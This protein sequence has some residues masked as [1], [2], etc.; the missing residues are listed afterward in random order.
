MREIWDRS[1]QPHIWVQYHN[2]LEMYQELVRARSPNGPL[3]VLDVGCAQATLALLLSE[4]GH[5]VLAIDLRQQFLQY[6]ASRYTHG[7]IRFVRANAL[8]FETQER[9][10]V[11]FANQIVEHLVYPLQLLSRLHDLLATNGMLVVTTPNWAYAVSRLPSFTELGEASQYDDRQ[12]SADGDG[13]FFAYKRIELIKLFREAGLS[14]IRAQYFESPFVSGHMKV[15][16]A[17][18]LA[19]ESTLKLLDRIVLSVPGLRRVVAHQLLVT[20]VKE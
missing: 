19:P 4:A 16:Y 5:D 3:K 2:Q 6:A 14:C 10:D 15:R 9:F 13:H 18:G 11:I 1:I 12:F 7:A 17:H 20:G 8:E